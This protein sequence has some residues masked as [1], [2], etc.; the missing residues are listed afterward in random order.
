M[1]VFLNKCNTVLFALQRKMIR[2]ILNL[3]FRA[4][5]DFSHL[6]RLGWLSV[7]DRVRYF[8]LL[9]VFHINSKVAPEYMMGNFRRVDD[10]HSY[11]TRG[12]GTDFYVP[13]IGSSEILKRSFLSPS[14]RGFFRW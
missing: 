12:S 8:K 3:D 2:F 6:K 4:H 13:K 10:I 7:V 14:V 5:V 1:C 9:H 11:G